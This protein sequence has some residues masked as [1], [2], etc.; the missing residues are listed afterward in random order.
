MQS[1][2]STTVG[3]WFFAKT[4]T[5]L[6]RIC[7]RLTGGRTSMPQLLAGLPVLFVTTTG[8]KTRQPRQ[9]PLIA[10]PT[11]DTLA[12]VGTNFGQVSTPG[13]VFNLEADPRLAVRYR[14]LDMEL[15]ARPA[16]ESEQAEVWAAASTV[17]PGYRQYQ[18]RITGRQVRIFVLEPAPV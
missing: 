1:F 3:A 12:L 14:Q 4:L 8:A 2:G 6:D 18:A 15:V 16:T 10:V 13:W 17:Y 7:H 11:G 9:S 5:P